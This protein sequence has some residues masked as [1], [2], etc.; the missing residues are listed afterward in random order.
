MRI[1]RSQ[2][3]LAQLSDGRILIGGDQEAAHV[4]KWN[5][6]RGFVGF[7]LLALAALVLLIFFGVKTRPRWSTLLL[8]ACAGA[9]SLVLVYLWVLSSVRISG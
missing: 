7:R 5:S 6:I 3:L 2:P 8:S 1:G 9:F 4:I